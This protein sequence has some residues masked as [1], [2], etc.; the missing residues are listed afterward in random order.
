MVN[1]ITVYLSWRETM[2]TIVSVLHWRENALPPVA[3]SIYFHPQ[4]KKNNK[5]DELHN[6]GGK[7]LPLIGKRCIRLPF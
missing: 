5:N 3:F 6:V 7:P 4:L 1:T 2:V